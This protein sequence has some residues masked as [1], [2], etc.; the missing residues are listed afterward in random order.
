MAGLDTL[1]EFSPRDTDPV[2]L[3]DDAI[4]ETRAKTKGSFG[5]E[6]Y[7]D[8][9]HKVPGGAQSLRPA[10]GRTG[11]LYFN[12]DTK[13][14]EYDDGAA[15]SSIA[16]AK[17]RATILW[18]AAQFGIPQGATRF[19]APFD[20]IIDDPGGY[21]NVQNH[22]IIQPANSIGIVS[23]YLEFAPPT[24]AGFGIFTYIEQFDGTAWQILTQ[25]WLASV[26]FTTM[27]T[28]VDSRWG[29]QL[30]VTITNS[31][32]ANMYVNATALGASPRFGYAMLG[33]T[34]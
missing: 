24:N 6:H 28:M 22:Q 29:L 11:R 15:W 34:A 25:N 14:A 5:I 13:A 17:A 26:P 32:P 30:R 10:A 12:T 27:T 9:P 8:G 23:C 33:R 7:L 19:E 2:S 31:T 20:Y 3:G 16:D 21:A 4:R 1:D 18:H